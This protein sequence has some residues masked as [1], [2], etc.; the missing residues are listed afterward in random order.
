MRCQIILEEQETLPDRT[1]NV[2]CDTPI[3]LSENPDRTTM[4]PNVHQCEINS[5]VK[6]GGNDVDDHSIHNGWIVVEVNSHVEK[7]FYRI[8]RQVMRKVTLCHIKYN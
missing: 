7:I 2:K 1:I 5:Y 3:E 8:A 4:N 6:E